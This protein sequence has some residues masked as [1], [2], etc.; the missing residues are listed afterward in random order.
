MHC[1]CGS[2]SDYSECCERLHL[3]A[4][5]AIT[6]EQLMRS[7]FSAFALRDAEYLAWSWDPSTRP[8][9]IR[10]DEVQQWTELHIAR[11]AG[12]LLDTEGVVEFVARYVREGVAGEM[13]ETSRFVRHGGRWVYLDGSGS[14]VDDV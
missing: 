4:T 5:P 2:G 8:E 7:R 6:A 9:K 12:G 11:S 1:P 3:H 13:H 10:V 14:V